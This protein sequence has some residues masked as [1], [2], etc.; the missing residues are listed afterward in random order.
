MTLGSSGQSSEHLLI[1]LH[2]HGQHIQRRDAF[3]DGDDEFDACVDGFPEWSL[4]RTVLV[5]L[6]IT[7]AVAPVAATAS[8]TVLNTAGEVGGAAFSRGWPPTILVPY[9]MACS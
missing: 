8:R 4:C 1:Q 9:A 2:F 6:K 7:E 5:R 3:S